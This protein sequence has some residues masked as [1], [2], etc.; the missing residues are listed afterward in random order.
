LKN[1]QIGYTLPVS[2]TKKFYVNKFRFFVSGQNLIT[3]TKYSGADPEVG[4]ISSTNYLSRGVDIG[5]YP[6]AKTITGG[7][8]IIF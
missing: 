6:Q 4:Q 1:L 7:I 5:S 2:L 3:F 8:N